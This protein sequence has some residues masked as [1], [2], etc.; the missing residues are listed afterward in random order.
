MKFCTQCG[1]QLD[2]D[3]RFCPSCGTQVRDLTESADAAPVE[4]VSSEENP[5]AAA[6]P[7]AEETDFSEPEKET[8]VSPAA[9]APQQVSYVYAAP[10]EANAPAPAAASPA[11]VKKAN[12]AFPILALVLAGT[13]FL[14]VAVYYGLLFA[15]NNLSGQTAA[16]FWEFLR[17]FPAIVML[18][19]VVAIPF[20]IIGLI[21]GIR[22]KKVACIVMSAIALACVSLVS[23]LVGRAETV[24]AG[25]WD[26]FDLF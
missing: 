26:L 24:F 13:G 20:G 10:A 22:S 9:P 8:D 11:P 2:D 18:P 6:A 19:C 25:L 14:L 3:V 5:S 21:R 12:T 23:L 16:G 7:V 1:R 15:A 17:L 4:P